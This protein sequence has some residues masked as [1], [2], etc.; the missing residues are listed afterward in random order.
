MLTN[1]VGGAVLGLAFI[2][3]AKSMLPNKVGGGYKVLASFASQSKSRK[4]RIKCFLDNDK[5]K[6]FS[7]EID[8]EGKEGIDFICQKRLNLTCVQRTTDKKL[9]S[10]FPQ[11]SNI[12]FSR[13]G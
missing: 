6:K 5:M 4:S 9:D 12:S 13:D 11:I 10:H 3:L 8:L 7:F 2:C 1:K